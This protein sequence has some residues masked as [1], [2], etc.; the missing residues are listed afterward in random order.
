MR[1]QPSLSDIRAFVTI[2]EH[3]SF[4]SAADVLNSSRAH[5]SRQLSQLEKNLGVKLIF[6]TTRTQRLTET[7]EQ[8]YKQCLSSLQMIDQAVVDAQE[9][10]QALQGSIRINC[11]GGIIGEDIL[12]QMIA[13][14]NLQYPDINIDL[15]FSSQRVDLIGEGFD[16]VIR[17]GDLEDSSLIARKLT[18][19]EV[20]LLASPSYLAR[21]EPIIHPKN[22]EQHNCLTGTVKRWQFHQ[23]AE[24]H[25]NAMTHALEIK[26]TGNFICKSGRALING[27]LKGNGIVRLP[28]LYCENEIAQGSLVSVFEQNQVNASTQWHSPDVPLFLLYHQNKYQPARL[29]LLIDFIYQQFQQQSKR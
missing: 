1:N 2:A 8:F 29:R 19:I 22:L 17:M 15:D 12:A 3:G 25:N 27:A 28:K 23:R 16:L 20:V 5:I 6:R 10:T 4:T 13:D 24:K 21:T 26:V 14:F 11:V 7:G 9:D 18:N